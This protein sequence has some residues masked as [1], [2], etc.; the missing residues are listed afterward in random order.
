ME[1]VPVQTQKHESTGERG[2]LVPV[3]EPLRTSQSNQVARREIVDVRRGIV[4]PAVSRPG[5]RGLHDVGL[6]Y[7]VQPSISFNLLGVDREKDGFRNPPCLSSAIAL[8]HLARARKTASYSS[9]I[10]W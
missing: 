5:E 9:M 6:T 2:A 10:R 7:A 1:L 8:A 4:S 3:V